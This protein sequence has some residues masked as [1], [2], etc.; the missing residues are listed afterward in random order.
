MNVCIFIADSNGGFPVPAVKD[1][2][3]Q[4]LVEHLIEQNSQKK[5]CNLVVV[6]IYDEAAEQASKKYKNVEFIWIKPPKIIKKLDSILFYFIK[7]VLHNKKAMSYRTMFSLLY[8]IRKSSGILKTTKYDKVV[9][10]NNIPLASIIKKSKYKGEYYYHL[11]NV[12]RI[13]FNCKKVFENCTGYLCVSNYVGKE[14]ASSQ[15]PIGPVSKSKIFTLYNCIDTEKF[16]VKSDSTFLKKIR[17]KYQINEDEKILIFVGRLSAEK[18]IDKVLES[19]TLIHDEKFKLL[20]VGSIMHSSNIKDEFQTKLNNIINDK[21]KD[22]IIFTGYIEQ[23]ELP[24]YYNV[25]DIAIMP[26]MWEE[27]AGLTMVEALCCG[28][29][30]ITTKSGGIPEYVSDYAIILEKNDKLVENMATQ[31]K[32]LINEKS[33]VNN[34]KLTEMY[35]KYTLNGYMKKFVDILNMSGT[36]RKD[37]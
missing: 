32:L 34:N 12:P 23:N 6:S 15:N 14:V 19:L 22:K 10:E 20:V 27:P 13:N 24:K 2:A 8:Y 21:L 36:D 7:N 16:C 4:I 25:A 31:I 5:E 1:G 11:H 3:V 29:K 28:A 9:I 35:N 37:W 17:E 26:S 18:G 30:L 33:K